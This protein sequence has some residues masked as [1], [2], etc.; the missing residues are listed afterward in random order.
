MFEKRRADTS[1]HSGR[2]L[3]PVSLT[4][5]GMRLRGSGIDRHFR[6]CVPTPSPLTLAA[7]R[8]DLSREAGEVH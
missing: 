7:S 1:L 3:N 6:A 4:Q 8:L 5:F 2:W